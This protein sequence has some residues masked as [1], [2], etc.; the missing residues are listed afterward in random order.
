VALFMRAIA[1]CIRVA[2]VKVRDIADCTLNY[3][4]VIVE[5]LLADGD[6]LAGTS[7]GESAVAALAITQPQSQ[8]QSQ[9]H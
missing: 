6:D 1:V 8:S 2:M 5:I 4:P 3:K 7:G 9:S